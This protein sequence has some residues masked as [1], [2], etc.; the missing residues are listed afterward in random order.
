MTLVSD[1]KVGL[2]RQP[3]SQLDP[4]QAYVDLA[5]PIGNGL[6]IRGGKFFTLLGYEVISPAGN[7][8]FSHSF[9]FG[10]LPFTQTG[11]L[12]SYAINDSLSV[13][14][15]ATRGWDQATEDN[16]GPD[17]EFTGQVKYTQGKFTFYVNG[18]TG[19]E[20]PSF[21]VRT[22][23]VTGATRGLN[24]WRSVIDVIG[25]YNYSDN[26]TLAVNA[27]YAFEA[28]RDNGGTAQW[29]G[30]AAYAGYKITDMFTFNARGEIF[31]DQDGD[32][33]STVVG[34]P[35]TYIEAT[36]G[37]TVTPFP[38]N[39]FASNLKIRPEV[40]FDYA[41]SRVRH[42][43]RGGDGSLPVDRRSGRVLHVLS[44]LV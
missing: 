10:N 4:T 22:D 38:N 13:T 41:T 11:L 27:D 30:I 33:P 5:I 28:Q 16:N 8:F 20:E 12:G 40:R 39:N 2:N 7:A 9:L 25:S 34:I 24:G 21:A 17:I 1:G 6:D 44:S 42:R 18:S 35:N 26:L 23:P 19:N 29:Y 14:G 32:A 3:K 15:G 43:R 36:L 37:L 31:D